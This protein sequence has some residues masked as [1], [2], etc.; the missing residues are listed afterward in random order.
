MAE[1]EI[2]SQS[3]LPYDP[4]DNAIWSHSRVPGWASYKVSNS[5][6]SHYATGLGIYCVFT[7]AN[8]F[9]FSAIEQPA[10]H[11]S[12]EPKSVLVRHAT[13]VRFGGAANSGIDH[14]INALGATIND[15]NKEA[16]LESAYE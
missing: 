2:L 16:Q 4:P 7:N 12:Y 1:E 6:T 3:E 11:A 10:S 15:S 5:V 8:V 14:V 13:T 9:G